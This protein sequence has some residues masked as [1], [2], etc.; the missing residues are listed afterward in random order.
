M[1]NEPINRI[2]HSFFY[3]LSKKVNV[4]I[5]ENRQHNLELYQIVSNLI[6]LCK[7]SKKKKLENFKNKIEFVS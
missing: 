7:K 2:V 1:A 6:N 3:Y 4:N 5:F